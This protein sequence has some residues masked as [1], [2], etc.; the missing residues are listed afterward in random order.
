MAR[1]YTRLY[2]VSRSNLQVPCDSPP[3]LITSLEPYDTRGY[4]LPKPLV[5]NDEVPSKPVFLAQYITDGISPSSSVINFEEVYPD[6]C[7]WTP[8][9]LM[10]K[11][12]GYDVYGNEIFEKAPP[13]ITYA[14][15]SVYENEHE[16]VAKLEHYKAYKQSL[17]ERKSSECFMLPRHMPN[18]TLEE[19]AKNVKEQREVYENTGAKVVKP[20]IRRKIDEGS[21]PNY[22]VDED[23][24]PKLLR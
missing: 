17:S 16:V 7:P 13:K 1:E 8:E 14:F 24:L 22:T 23:K 12:F 21:Y 3:L 5:E 15:G 20:R 6:N 10:P 11:T 18:Y 19:F 4:R 2:S 9:P